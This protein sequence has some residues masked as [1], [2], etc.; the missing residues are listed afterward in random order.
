MTATLYP[1]RIILS[2]FNYAGVEDCDR[3][4]RVRCGGFSVHNEHAGNR[5][6][7]STS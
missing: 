1:R 7:R 5:V 6:G 3:E 4:A 2:A